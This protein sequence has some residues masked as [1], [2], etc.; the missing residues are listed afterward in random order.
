MMRTIFLIFLTFVFSL[1]AYSVA[2]DDSGVSLELRP[3]NCLPG[4]VVKLDAVMKRVDFAEFKL[5]VPTHPSLILV[6]KEHNPVTFKDGFYYQTST[7]VLQPTEAGEFKLEGIKLI[8]TQEHVTTEHQLAAPLLSVQS[9]NT[10]EDSYTPEL[11]SPSA[12]NTTSNTPWLLLITLSLGLGLG[13]IIIIFILFFIKRSKRQSIDQESTIELSLDTI[14]NALESNKL[15]TGDIEKLLEDKNI[16]L[17]SATRQALEQKAY[18]S[19]SN[20][21]ELLKIIREELNK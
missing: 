19:S 2:A 8:L 9:Y 17:H 5:T 12:K 20:D 6:A 10:K 16:K 1:S 21:A 7:W 14:Y 13:L 18:S 15:D 11:L 4:D 3:E